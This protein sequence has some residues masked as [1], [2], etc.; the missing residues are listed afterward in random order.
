MPDGRLD[1]HL[2]VRPVAPA[3]N[4][5]WLATLEAE[6]KHR[7]GWANEVISPFAP[8]A[9]DGQSAQT[10]ASGTVDIPENANGKAEKAKVLAPRRGGRRARNASLQTG[11]GTQ[12]P[13]RQGRTR[14]EP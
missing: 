9:A 12:R 2:D 13:R 7:V 1:P 5:S 6:L 11:H 14:Q 4:R 8:L 10:K 3:A